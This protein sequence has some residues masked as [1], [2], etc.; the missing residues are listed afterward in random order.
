MYYMYKV[1]KRAISERRILSR[2]QA[3]GQVDPIVAS[4][5]Y[6]FKVVVF[7]FKSNG[8]VVDRRTAKSY[9]YWV[10]VTMPSNAEKNMLRNC[11]ICSAVDSIFAEL[12]SNDIRS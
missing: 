9:L 12:N 5:V 1:N 3:F 8:S 4:A 2:K 10:T 7:S 6:L 11:S